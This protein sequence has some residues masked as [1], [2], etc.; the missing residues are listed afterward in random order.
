M[1]E[2]SVNEK[3]EKL[4]TVM[5]EKGVDV[6]YTTTTDFHNSEYIQDYF[7]A[8]CWYGDSLIA[9]FLSLPVVLPSM[10]I[11][12]NVVALLKNA[13]NQWLKSFQSRQENLEEIKNNVDRW[14]L[15]TER[16]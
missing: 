15:Y 13:K 5:K 7:K 8:I 6:Y 3:I 11:Q 16:S 14:L 9:R 1:K 2:L 4:R 10:D 12:S